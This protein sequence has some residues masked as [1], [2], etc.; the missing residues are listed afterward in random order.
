MQS[1]CFRCGRAVPSGT[2]GCGVCLGVSSVALAS[3]LPGASRS[4]LPPT[5]TGV[6]LPGLPSFLASRAAPQAVGP[7]VQ[8]TVE[9]ASVPSA[10][11]PRQE[12]ARGA[13]ALV[14]LGAVLAVGAGVGLGER[15]WRLRPRTPGA[16]HPPA[17]TLPTAPTPRVAPTPVRAPGAV[18]ETRSEAPTLTVGMASV[19]WKRSVRAPEAALGAPDGRY[20]SVRGGF[21]TLQ[22][23]PGEHLVSDGTP[24]PD[25]WVDVD[26][27]CPGPY[28]VEVGVGHNDYVVVADGLFGSHAVDLDARGVRAGR[29]V[30]VSTGSGGGAL[31]LD[32][33]RVRVP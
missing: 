4:P 3:L 6:T 12:Q 29:Y 7:S 25:L 17:A 20:A 1:A 13:R 11:P 18:P 24:F 28:R 9:R 27:R 16:Q 26:P 14:L 19:H 10:V 33:V 23:A 21:V 8:A 22:V 30:R 31:G 15:L 32:A 2:V 5:Q